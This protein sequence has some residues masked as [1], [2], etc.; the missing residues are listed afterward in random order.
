M[1]KNISIKNPI[2]SIDWVNNPN[3]ISRLPSPQTLK[4]ITR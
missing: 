4:L 3:L 1:T 2:P